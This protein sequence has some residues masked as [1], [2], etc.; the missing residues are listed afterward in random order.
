MQHPDRLAGARGSSDADVSFGNDA[1]VSSKFRAP[2]QAHQKQR[3]RYARQL[4]FSEFRSRDANRGLDQG[5][6]AD[7]R[8][9]ESPRPSP[10]H[11]KMLAWW[12]P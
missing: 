11:A 8:P 10:S 2:V 4:V 3:A 1:L 12:R 7:R 6:F 5:N 9:S